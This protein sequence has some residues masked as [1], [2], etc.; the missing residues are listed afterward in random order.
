MVSKTKTN[1]IVGLI[2]TGCMANKG[3]DFIAQL[4]AKVS[5]EKESA[6]HPG[7]KWHQTHRDNHFGDCE[8]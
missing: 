1:N 5:G 4:R 6:G 7:K 8:K 3:A 2:A